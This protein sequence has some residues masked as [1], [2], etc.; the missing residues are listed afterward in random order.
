MSDFIEFSFTRRIALAVLTLVALFVALDAPP[1][2]QLGIWA[3]I[4]YWLSHIGFGVMAALAATWMLILALESRAERSQPKLALAIRH[5]SQTLSW[6]VVFVG[7]TLGSWLFAALAM[8][9]ESMFALSETLDDDTDWLDLWEQR[10]GIWAW[11]AEWLHLYPGYIL[12]WLLLNAGPLWG[13]G[14]GRTR[15]AKSKLPKADLPSAG[16][17]QDVTEQAS[18][19]TEADAERRAERLAADATE[20]RAEDLPDAEPIADALLDTSAW[21][22]KGADL[23]ADQSA[24]R[25]PEAIGDELVVIRSDLHYLEIVTRGGTATVLGNLSS[26][27]ER[28]KSRG[29]LV[30]RSY[31]VAFSEIKRVG[32]GPQGWQ[33]ELSTGH[34]VPI[35]R[36]RVLEARQKFGHKFDSRRGER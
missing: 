4:G 35:S 6:I 33:C 2:D 22:E 17:S 14:Q 21:A 3:A 15:S 11:C 16:G 9:L 24:L 8:P 13:G 27:A 31:W 32:R 25:L 23:G 18:T 36:R 26:V 19:N 34:R 1:A 7:G 10:G 28:L 30:H 12:A 5:P 29:M 20:L